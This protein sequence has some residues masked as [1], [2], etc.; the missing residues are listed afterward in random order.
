MALITIKIIAIEPLLVNRKIK[1]IKYTCSS[2]EGSEFIF[3][4]KVM[5]QGCRNCQKEFSKGAE[6]WPCS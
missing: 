6:T 3:K 2:A 1:Y 5:M 4:L